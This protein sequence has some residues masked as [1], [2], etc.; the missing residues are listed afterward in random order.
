MSKSLLSSSIWATSLALSVC[1]LAE[2][3]VEPYEGPPRAVLA[4]EGQPGFWF[5]SDV[6]RKMLAD[7]AL[8]GLTQQNLVLL[9]QKLDIREQQR[10]RFEEA[11]GLS[12]EA[13]RRSAEALAISEKRRAEA[14]EALNAWYRQPWLWGTLGLVSGV[15]V[16]SVIAG[17]AD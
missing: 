15:V 16:V 5:R 9:E 8:Y 10:K 12:L 7:L 2:E 1:A 3:P 4:Y 13:E 17:V 14:E 6:A 11:V